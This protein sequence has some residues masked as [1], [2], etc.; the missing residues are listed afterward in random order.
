MNLIPVGINAIIT[1]NIGS[2][3]FA[4][5]E[6]LTLVPYMVK[7][8]KAVNILSTRHFDSK[9]DYETNKPEIIISYN[10]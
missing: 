4:F 10:K 5:H 1:R 9:I 2:S 7:K 6:N 8:N 3:L